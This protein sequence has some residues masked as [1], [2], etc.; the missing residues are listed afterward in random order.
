MD[1]S[2]ADAPDDARGQML[3]AAGVVAPICQARGGEVEAG[4]NLAFKRPMSGDIGGPEDGAVALRAEVGVA[5]ENE[6]AMRRIAA[7]AVVDGAG[8]EERIDVEILRAGADVQIAAVRRQVGLGLVGPDGVEA[9]AQ[10]IF[11]DGLPV[12]VRRVGIGGV[13]VGAG[14]VIGQAVGRRAVGEMLE[15]AL[16]QKR[17]RS[18]ASLGSKR[19]QTLIMVWKPISC[20]CWFIAVGIRPEIGNEIHLAHLRVVEPVDDDDIGGQMAFAIAF[21]DGQHFILRTVALLALDVAVGGL[22]QH[23]RCSG[24]KAVAGINFVRR[25]A[26]DDEE[27]DAVA[28]FGGPAGA[29]IEAAARSWSLKDCPR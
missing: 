18:S 19:G 29:L 9:F 6:G 11:L 7:E 10:D 4:G 23:R 16:L 25:F 17:N 8:M 1:R 27:R 3:P 12:P 24:Q 2:A 26:G 13:D 5:R 20:S 28:Y 22:G 21:R 15:P 14:L